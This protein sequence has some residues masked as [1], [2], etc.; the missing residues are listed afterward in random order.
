MP[1][2]VE[3]GRG[4]VVGLL[5]AFA[6]PPVALAVGAATGDVGET[7]SMVAV[8]FPLAAITAVLGRLAL[9]VGSS[10]DAPDL[11]DENVAQATGVSSE[12]YEEMIDGTELRE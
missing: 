9:H 4:W 7:A 11:V 3:F 2:D 1:R 6:V 10:A 12:E 5:L 8:L